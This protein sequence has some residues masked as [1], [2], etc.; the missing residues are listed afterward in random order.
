MLRVH[1]WSR[2]EAGYAVMSMQVIID[3]LAARPRIDAADMGPF[4]DIR[5]VV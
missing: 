1:Q 3:I 2:E 5:I 4:D